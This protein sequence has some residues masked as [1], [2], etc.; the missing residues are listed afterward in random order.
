MA[1]IALAML[2]EGRAEWIWAGA[3]DDAGIWHAHILSPSDR[4]DL[5]R[6]GRGLVRLRGVFSTVA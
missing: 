4:R 6:Q 2:S 3:F 5:L 1:D